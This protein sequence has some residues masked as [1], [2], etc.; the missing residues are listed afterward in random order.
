MSDLTT[1]MLY[2]RAY[3]QAKHSKS[4]S[5]ATLYA[6]SRRHA[7]RGRYWS[8]G[9][10]GPRR[11]LALSEVED[12]CRVDARSYAGL[13]TVPIGQIRGSEGR[14]ADFDRDFHPLQDHCRDRWLSVAAARDQGKTLPPV[15]LVQVGNVYFCRDGHHRISVAR[16]LGQLDVEAEV[17]VWHVSGP[18]PWETRVGSATLSLEGQGMREAGRSKIRKRGPVATWLQSLLP[19]RTRA[20][21]TAPSSSAAA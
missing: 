11:L 13:R 8:S 21:L 20:R 4:G 9:S 15:V 10:R 6:R 7:R 18:L 16:A 17:T 14:C 1:D 5:A 3:H 19:G 2:A 12:A